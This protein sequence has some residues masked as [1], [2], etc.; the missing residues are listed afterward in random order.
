DFLHSRRMGRRWESMARANWNKQF[1]RTA[2]SYS[3]SVPLARGKRA[4]GDLSLS[5]SAFSPPKVFSRFCPAGMQG[6]APGSVFLYRDPIMRA[7]FSISC[8]ALSFVAEAGDVGTR[9]VTLELIPENRII[10]AGVPF[11]VGLQIRH[12]KGF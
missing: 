3:W 7:I 2:G 4:A 1:F 9:G 8:A 6:A 5:D 11:Q 10:A 12:E